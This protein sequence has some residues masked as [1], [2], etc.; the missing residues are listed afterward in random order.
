METVIDLGEVRAEVQQVGRFDYRIS[1]R[2]AAA[3]PPAGSWYRFGRARAERKASLELLRYI[4]RRD[5]AV[6]PVVV[7]RAA[8]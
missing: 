6:G 5:W 7:F 8:G 1:V 2:S 4:R 3:G